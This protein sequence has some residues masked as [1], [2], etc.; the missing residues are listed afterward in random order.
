MR[1]LQ[2][3]AET[4]AVHATAVPRQAFANPEAYLAQCGEVPHVVID[5]AWDSLDDYT[6]ATHLSEQQPMHMSLHRALAAAGVQTIVGIGT[7]AEYG[8]VN[9]P[10]CE[11][12]AVAPATAYAI[13]KHGVRV[14]LEQLAAT[15]GIQWRWLRLFGVWGDG[16]PART[17]Y[18]QVMRLRE[19]QTHRLSIPAPDR[20]VDVLP[21]DVMASHIVALALQ[22]HVDGV[23]NCGAGVGV[24][25]RALLHEW[26][27]GDAALL[28]RVTWGSAVSAAEPDGYWA[29]THLMDQA[30]AEHAVAGVARA[31]TPDRYS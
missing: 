25:I 27:G 19:D 16:Q 28:S 15:T 31:I 8:I 9:G 26:L 20:R 5:L 2:G 4:G 14:A 18:G 23:I 30:L 21:A 12:M 29:D 7:A 17:L 1:V 10:L 22:T 11:T 13:A 6:L 3:M 24:P